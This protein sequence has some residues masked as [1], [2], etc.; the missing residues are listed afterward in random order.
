[1]FLFALAAVLP[2]AG[3]PMTQG[4][5]QRVVAHLEMTESWLVSEVENLSDAQM[6]FRPT[7]ESWSITE[8]VEHLAIAEPQ[9][10]QRIK[11]S[12]KQPP[13]AE[14]LPATDAQILWYG[15]DRTNRA[16]TGEARVP[17]GKY[18]TA[19]AALADVRKLRSEML[20]YAK[21]TQ[22]DLRGHKLLEGNMD[23]YQW[24][25]MISTHSQ[26]HILQ[27]RENKANAGYPRR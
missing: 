10:W 19:A 3:E 25:L 7:P 5:R 23:V 14:K 15:I 16:K 21:A 22:E 11:D 8:V 4:D 9:Y 26:R 17:T 13:A 18:Q 12:M 6:K 2:L 1:M 20:D 24:L 27:I